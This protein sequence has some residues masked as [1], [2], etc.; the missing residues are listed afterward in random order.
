[1]IDKHKMRLEESSSNS[2]PRDSVP[3]HEP[4]SVQPSEK[5]TSLVSEK[6]PP[7]YNPT[8]EIVQWL[9]QV[10]PGEEDHRS[11]RNPSSTPPASQQSVYK[12]VRRGAMLGL[13]GSGGWVPESYVKIRVPVATAA[14]AMPGQQGQQGQAR[15]SSP[16]Q[17]A[18]ECPR[19]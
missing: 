6:T 14:T 19:A 13:G 8:P 7:S 16:I 9:A 12:Y 18:S 4:R 11:P 15:L 1:M 17:D 5:S 10:K 3:S 2:V